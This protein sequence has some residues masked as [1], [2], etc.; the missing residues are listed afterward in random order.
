MAS[1][2]KAALA[3]RRRGW[4]V[5][6]INAQTKKAL[7]RWEEF[8]RRR[9]TG[10]EIRKWWHRWPDANVGIVTGKVSG[11]VVVD[12]DKK[13]E[14]LISKLPETGLKSRTGS[15][16]FHYFYSYPPN[17][18]HVP[19]VVRKD[20]FD[21]RG[22]GGYVVAPP[23]LHE[24]G[25]RYAWLADTAKRLPP[26]PSVAF[27]EPKE[28]PNS[29]G[30]GQHKPNDGNWLSRIMDGVG[31]GERN[32]A[33]TRLAGYYFSKHMPFDVVLSNIELWN[34]RNDPPLTERELVT[35]L[36]SVFGKESRRPNRVEQP[37]VDNGLEEPFALVSMSDYMSKFGDAEISWAVEG[38]LPDATIA[39][40]VAPPG[41]YKTW[42]ELDLAVSI[43]TGTPFLKLF[44]TNRQGPVIIVQ[45]EDFHGTMAERLGTIVNSK[46]PLASAQSANGDE[47]TAVM[48]PSL[49]IYLHPDR[50]LR[51]SDAVVLEAL[52][53][54]VAKIRPRLVIID[55]LYSAG[56]TDD[57]LAQTVNQMFALKAMRDRYGCSFVLAH[58]TA[59]NTEGTG[60]EASW[61]SQFVNAFLETG[62]QIRRKEAQGQIVVRRHF[63]SSPDIEEV[64]V[65]LDISTVQP[66]RYEISVREPTAKDR[67]QADNGT[68]I[69]SVF[70]QGGAFTSQDVAKAINS[71]R[72]TAMRRLEKL[73]ETNTLK[74]TLDGRYA[75]VDDMTV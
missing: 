70:A 48:P 11:L 5:I 24:S 17:T 14:H 30:N 10:A 68:S 20:G 58:H 31:H 12:A 40:M 53:E 59:K 22:D 55:P 60:R 46:F 26:V 63:K 37:R 33:A 64:N 41:S 65:T 52:E 15:G 3:Y 75:L 61:G 8:Q 25:R 42:L 49:P 28:G 6:P 18:E 69:L 27:E 38:W 66:Y 13:A 57:Y 4:S 56:N 50:R 16:W 32:D 35:T 44:K 2:L 29:N 1:T 54:K 7:I 73:V 62:W 45:Q 34:E 9:A 36:R 47:F 39:L 43:A 67:Q 19:N 23:S 21:V 51:F 71:H 74:K 72:T